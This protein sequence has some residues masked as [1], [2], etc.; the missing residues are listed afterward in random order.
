MEK[1]QFIIKRGGE[2]F[3]EFSIVGEL[4]T[5]Y[6]KIKNPVLVT[7]V[8]GGNLSFKKECWEK[9]GGYDENFIG[10]CINEDSDFCIRLSNAFGKILFSPDLAVNHLRAPQGSRA[11]GNTKSAK[12]YEHLFY[13]HLYFYLKHWPKI[14]LPFFFLYRMRQVYTCI[15]R[16]GRLRVSYVLAPLIGYTRAFKVQLSKSKFQTDTK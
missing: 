9:I 1:E 13:N 12:W 6:R 2:S 14:Y 4:N 16:Y 5:D 3:G 7:A 8:P 10:N 15:V 11:F